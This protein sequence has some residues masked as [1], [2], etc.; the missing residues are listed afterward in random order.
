[1]SDVFSLQ[2]SWATSP[3]SGCPSGKPSLGAPLAEQMV[4]AAKHLDDIELAADIP[5]FV[6]FGGV[7]SANVVVIKSSRKVKVALTSADG[8]AQVVPVDGLF[9]LLALTVPITAITLT[10]LAGVDTVVEVFLGEHA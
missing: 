1:M 9:M 10:R 6:S 4:L 5:F 3:A 2:G 7:A 8:A